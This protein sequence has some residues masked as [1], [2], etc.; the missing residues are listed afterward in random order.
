MDNATLKIIGKKYFLK[1]AKEEP[2]IS[3]ADAAIRVL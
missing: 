3:F 1:I 2:S